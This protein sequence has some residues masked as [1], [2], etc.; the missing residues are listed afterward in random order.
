NTYFNAHV[1]RHPELLARFGDIPA[2]VANEK[3]YL[4]TRV[5]YKLDLRG[6]C[7]NVST[8]C[9]TS[10]VAVCHAF[11]SLLDYQCDI[12][13]A[14]GISVLCPQERGYLYQEGSIYSPDGHCRPFDADANGTVFGNGG[15]VV[16]LK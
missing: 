9:S 13:L 4:A 10:L 8:A 11:N 12:A 2:L 15:G 1:A 7:V 3:D 14:G 16:V 5:G 6:P